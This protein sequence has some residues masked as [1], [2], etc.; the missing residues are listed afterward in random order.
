MSHNN[1]NSNLNI[2]DEQMLLINILNTMYNDNLR[3]IDNLTASNNDIRNLI[4][5]TLNNSSNR[6]R[7]RTYTNNRERY[8]YNNYN[9]S[10]NRASPNRQTFGHRDITNNILYEYIS[11]PLTAN[12]RSS[13]NANSR[14]NNSISEILQS[15]FEPIEIY[16]TQLQIE[17]ATRNVRYSD[18]LSP[19]NRSCPISLENFSDNDIVS[20]IRFCGHIFNTEQLNTWFRSNCRCPVCRYDI[21][22]YNAVN[23]NETQLQPIVNE[24]NTDNPQQNTTTEDISNIPHAQNNYSQASVERNNNTNLSNLYYTLFSSV[25]ADDLLDFILDP[26][27]NMSSNINSNIVQNIVNNYQ[28]RNTNQ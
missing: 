9:Y 8:N 5:Q 10:N 25:G 20:V 4:T 18:I 2:S 24:P 17:S 28:R 1:S 13:V 26:S 16:P 21:R 27:G 3:Q 6:N 19:R 7:S 15:F 12:N 14:Q 11:P 23:S 22:N